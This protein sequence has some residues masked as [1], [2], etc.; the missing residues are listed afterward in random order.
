MII[1]NFAPHPLDATEYEYELNFDSDG[2]PS[3]SHIPGVKATTSILK[4]EEA[5]H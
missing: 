3:C 4:C 1:C 5:D 2:Q